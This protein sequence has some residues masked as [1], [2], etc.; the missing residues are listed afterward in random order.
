LKDING[1]L[2]CDVA[3]VREVFKAARVFIEK[4]GR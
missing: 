3:M 2:I 4:V 1:I